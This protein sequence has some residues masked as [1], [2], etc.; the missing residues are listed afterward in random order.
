MCLIFVEIFESQLS[1][2]THQSCFVQINCSSEIV[3]FDTVS[4]YDAIN[5]HPTIE[6][7]DS[8]VCFRSE[9]FTAI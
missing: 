9:I 2:T 6:I 7:Y 8:F 4:D 3:T 5:T 1:R